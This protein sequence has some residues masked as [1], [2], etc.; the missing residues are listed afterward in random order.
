LID[1]IGPIAAITISEAR[2]IGVTFNRELPNDRT[3]VLAA[4]EKD[5]GYW[6]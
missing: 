2:E 3:E 5:R 1:E 6:N 4:Q